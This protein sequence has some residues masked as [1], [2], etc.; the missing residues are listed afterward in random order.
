MHVLKGRE[1]NG[2]IYVSVF[3][4]PDSVKEKEVWITDLQDVNHI[5][6]VLRMKK[7]EK[8]SLCCEEKE[9]NMYL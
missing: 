4:Q 2:G 5:R 7:G 3:I 8:I 6:N 1:W 9:R